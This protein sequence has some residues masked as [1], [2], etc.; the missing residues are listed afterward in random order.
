MPEG[1]A[2]RPAAVR[3]APSRLRAAALRQEIEATHAELEATVAALEHEDPGDQ[4]G[5][6][7]QPEPVDPIAP[8]LAPAPAALEQAEALPELGPALSPPP[9]ARRPL[10]AAALTLAAGLGAGLLLRRR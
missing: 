9:R 7:E 4:P 8:A 2:S 10:S 1:P 3:F 6:H 5:A